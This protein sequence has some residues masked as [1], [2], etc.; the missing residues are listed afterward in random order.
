MIIPFTKAEAAGN[1]FVIVDN[2]EGK[3]EK[4]VGDFSQLAKLVCRRK[5]SVGADGLLVLEDSPS[6]DFK[7]RVINPDGS[8][9]AMCGNGIRSSA[10]YAF[11]KEWCGPFMKIETGAGIL[12]AEINDES[13]KV[14]MTPPEGIKLD[15]NIGV[16]KN[17][18][19]IHA[20]NTGVPHAVHFVENIEKYPVK[21][22][23]SGVRYHKVFQPEGINA[24]FVEIKD[25][26]TILVRTYER[27]VE[28][29][30]LACGTGVV[31]A[32]IIS[33]LTGLTK[34]PVSAVTRSGDILKVYFKKEHGAFGDVYL[35]GK[36]HIIFDGGLNYV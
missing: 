4:E 5:Y 1:D 24:D 26:S 9:V 27:G 22:A 3:L 28:D 35:E 7:M 31:A 2:R 11:R 25:A 17:I 10:L 16:G 33:H 20:V 23:G 30:T 8:E 12:E 34:V 21:V 19:T 6:A 15:Q 36:A 14:K 29:E 32:A 18:M 13:I